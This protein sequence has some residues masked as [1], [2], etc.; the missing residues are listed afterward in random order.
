MRHSITVN[1]S[2]FAQTL[3]DA[4]AYTD[5]DIHSEAMNHVVLKVINKGTKLAV[6]ACDGHGYYERRLPLVHGKGEPKPSLPGKEQRLCISAQDA[7]ILHKRITT[8][9]LGYVTLEVDDAQAKDTRLLVTLKLPDGA[10]ATFFSRTDFE[11]PDF[12]NVLKTAE[13]G[14]KNAPEIANMS[15][16][17][18]EMV[19]IG[20]VLPAKGNSA[21]Q[22]HTAKG[23][24]KGHMVLMEY[25]NPSEE[26]DVRIIFT[27]MVDAA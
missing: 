4:T 1:A 17:V 20:K 8:R 22:M 2:L 19:R 24:N 15:I 11:V 14:K 21:A 12:S 16:P 9:V 18:H 23:V 25:N 6:T 5:K 13:K 10:S 26:M 3:K 27:L 7:L